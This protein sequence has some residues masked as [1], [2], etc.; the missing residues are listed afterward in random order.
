[1]IIHGDVAFLRDLY[2]K[3]INFNTM[4][5]LHIAVEPEGEDGVFG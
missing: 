5:I 3:V 4:F 1:M 2:C